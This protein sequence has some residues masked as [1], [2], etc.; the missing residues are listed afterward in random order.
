MYKQISTHLNSTDITFVTEYRNK[1]DTHQDIL[2]TVSFLYLI[3][4]LQNSMEGT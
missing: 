2:T 1:T 4:M 3:E